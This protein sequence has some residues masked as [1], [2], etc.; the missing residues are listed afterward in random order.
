[1]LVTVSCGDYDFLAAMSL[2]S[3]TS[4]TITEDTTSHSHTDTN[5]HQRRTEPSVSVPQVHNLLPVDPVHIHQTFMRQTLQ[6]SDA[7]DAQRTHDA[8]RLVLRDSQL[9]HFTCERFLRRCH[10]PRCEDSIRLKYSQ[11]N[12]S[13]RTPR[14]PHRS[15]QPRRWT[16]K[17]RNASRRLISVCLLINCLVCYQPH[18]ISGS[19]QVKLTGPVVIGISMDRAK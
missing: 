4:H 1:M 14:Q 12:L 16:R 19:V 13:N 10:L 17:A 15:N 6:F 2:Y 5:V 18:K 8:T 7:P 3:I 9:D 11:T